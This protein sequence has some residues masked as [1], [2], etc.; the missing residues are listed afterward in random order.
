MALKELRSAVQ[1]DCNHSKCHALLG[2]VYMN[3]KLAG[4][5]K[6]SFQQ[7]LKLNPQEPLALQCIGKVGGTTPDKSSESGKNKDSEKKG[8]FF[9]W[10]GGG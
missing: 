6:L 9:G 8:G 7:A 1:V 4:M 5:A 3:Q 10:L 2:V